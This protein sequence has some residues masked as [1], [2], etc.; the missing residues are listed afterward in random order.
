MFDFSFQLKLSGMA[1]SLP[2]IHG[3]ADGSAG[4]V[5][6]LDTALNRLNQALE[7]GGSFQWFPGIQTLGWNVHPSLVHFPIACLSLFFLF[8]IAGAFWR[9]DRMRPI[10]SALLYVGTLGALLAACAGLYAASTVP[11]GQTVHDIMEWHERLGLSVAGLSLVLSA[12][13]WLG[14]PPD[15]A[16]EKAFFWV[17][18]ASMTTAML[19]GADLGGLMVYQHGVAVQ[20]LQGVEAQQQH[21]HHN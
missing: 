8:E 15:T 2:Q 6:F 14:K 16:M 10:T 17:L 12:W 3:D 11:H 5:G 20:Q 21:M 18:S 7:S 1:G 13:R 19:F 9:G 4:L